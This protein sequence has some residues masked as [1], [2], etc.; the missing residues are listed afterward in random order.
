MALTQV[1]VTTHMMELPRKNALGKV[2][3]LLGV[4]WTMNLKILCDAN[5][6]EKVGNA[7]FSRKAS[8]PSTG[9]R[10]LSQ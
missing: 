9:N 1:V 3:T 6:K 5:L 10:Y 7:N 2:V 8:I 4:L